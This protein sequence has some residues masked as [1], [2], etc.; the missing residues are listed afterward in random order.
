MVGMTED[1]REAMEKCRLYNFASIK[2]F[3]D[4]EY[5]AYME[6][7]SIDFHAATVAYLRELH[8]RIK[9]I[10]YESF[11]A[12]LPDLTSGASEKVESLPATDTN[13]IDFI[14]V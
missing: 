7:I 9:A 4:E 11:A 13:V 6:E 2:G 12:M 14:V 10:S 5:S 1:I 3:D 8:H